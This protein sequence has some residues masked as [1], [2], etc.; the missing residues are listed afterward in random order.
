MDLS[1]VIAFNIALGAA[2]ASPGPALLV[3]IKTTLSSGRRAGIAVGLGLG[4]VA[5]LWTLAALLGLET[6]FAVFPWAYGGVKA[7][8]AL[9]LIYIAYQMWVHARAKVEA[10]MTPASHAFRQGVMINALNPKSV[11]FAAAVLVVIFPSGMSLGEN[12]FVVANHLAIEV[13]FY[14]GLAFGMSH[15]AV[16]QRY[17]RAK[18]YIDRVAAGVLGLLGLRLL[19]QR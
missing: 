18:V 2:I 19:F 5:A 10:Q 12:L 11:L 6:I 3:A 7:V 1:H 16:S 15:A 4:L 14:T 17:M 8:G 9:Y 13:L